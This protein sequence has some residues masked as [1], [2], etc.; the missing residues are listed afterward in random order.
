MQDSA[1]RGLS[2]D[3]T[4]GEFDA[5]AEEF[6]ERHRRGERDLLTEFVRRRP[7]LEA[8]ILQALGSI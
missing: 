3:S 5:L 7:D 6:V 8:K 2:G 4:G 1:R